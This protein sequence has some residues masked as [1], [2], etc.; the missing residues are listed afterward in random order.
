MFY[1]LYIFIS[2][3]GNS[4]GSYI[5]IESEQS[6]D[7]GN[8]AYLTSSVFQYSTGPYGRC[9]T[10][11]Y[12]ISGY[13]AGFLTFRVKDLKT[14]STYDL[15][16]L[17]GTSQGDH[18]NYGTFGFYSENPYLIQIIGFNGGLPGS[19]AIDDLIFQDSKYCEVFPFTAI[20]GPG[21]PKPIVT[22]TPNPISDGSDYDCTFEE[23]YCNWSNDTTKQ[24]FWLRANGKTDTVETG[25]SVDHTLG[26]SAG[27]YAHIETSYPAREDDSARMFSLPYTFNKANCFSFWYHMYGRD[28][29]KLS[30]FIRWTDGTEVKMWSESYD[31][32][33]RWFKASVSLDI[34]QEYIMILE[35]TRGS[36]YQG[37][38]AIGKI[39]DLC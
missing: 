7:K 24:L 1:N 6:T 22:T 38:I 33:D 26:T 29:G 2:R 9:L 5:Y 27:Y 30:M 39:V 18:W 25:P 13:D 10:F 15:W 19:V 34:D 4:L 8:V 32:G 14:G 28:V 12:Y 20:V 21:L 35:A 17:G 11:W 3:L 36:S 16:H 37:D 31:Q 23:D